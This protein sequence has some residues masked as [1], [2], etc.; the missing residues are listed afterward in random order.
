MFFGKRIYNF[1]QLLVFSGIC[2]I[3]FSYF[4]RKRKRLI[5]IVRFQTMRLHRH[6]IILGK[7]GDGIS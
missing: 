4:V 5:R 1:L 6:S 7:K 3:I 2:D